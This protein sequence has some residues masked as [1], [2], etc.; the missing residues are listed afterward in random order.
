MLWQAIFRFGSVKK[1]MGKMLQFLLNFGVRCVC[2]I[3]HAHFTLYVMGGKHYLFY[4]KWLDSKCAN[5]CTIKRN[6]R[7]KRLNGY[8]LFKIENSFRN[9]FMRAQASHVK[10]KEII[11]RS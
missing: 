3:M 9:P 11:R 6:V 1:E 2:I 7:G 5:F 4:R 10:G 8:S